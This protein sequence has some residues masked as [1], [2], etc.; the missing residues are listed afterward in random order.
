MVTL[1]SEVLLPEVP[2]QLP[3]LMFASPVPGTRSRNAM[4]GSRECRLV[5]ES[6]LRRHI[7]ERK[8]GL[9]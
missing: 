6:G 4:K 7:T 8:F 3:S 5:S 9:T 1:S 2:G